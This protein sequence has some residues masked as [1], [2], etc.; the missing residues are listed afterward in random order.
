MS[1]R[2]TRREGWA[3]LD[4]PPTEQML[5]P[6]LCFVEAYAEKLGID[7][8]RRW[9]LRDALS[10]AF[11]LVVR[12][13][14]SSSGAA[15]PVVIEVGERE[16]QLVVEVL[17]AGVP[18]K[19]TGGTC[20]D[21]AQEFHQAARHLDRL[22][23]DNLGRRGQAV[24]LGIRLGEAAARKALAGSLGAHTEIEATDADIT[25]R[26]MEA[27]EAPLFSQ[28]FYYVYGYDYIHE[29]VYYPD[30]VRQMIEEGKLISLVGTLPNG[31]LVGHVGL[32]KWNDEPPVYE[33]C[34]GV[35]DPH[36]KSRGLFGK[37]FQRTM[38]TVAEIP[39]QYLMF[40]FVTN[41]E[42][43]Q[44]FVARY[45]PVDLAIFIGCQSK[46][47]QARL[48]KLGLGQDSAEM[49]RYSLLYSVLPRVEHPF[50]A[51]IEL[52]MNLGELLGFLL[53]PL[54]LHWYPASR[55]QLL[56]AGGEYRVTLQPA[57]SAV[58]FDL[59]QPGRDAVDRLISEWHQLLRN[60]YQYA[61]V[62]VL[63]ETPGLGNLYD[64]LAEAGFF[65]AG[66][67]PYH[68]SDK[69]GIRFQAIGPTKVAFDDIKVH[70]ETAKKLL[71]II[72]Q[73]YERNGLL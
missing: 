37:I 55:F 63:V 4:I 7:R 28:L 49:D 23:I 58:I 32:I 51:E 29:F 15:K 25:I 34:L 44:R 27:S 12:N 33:P 39:M 17:N 8:D 60:G 64:I 61:G 26:R 40:D 9:K 56:A 48:E 10:M 20:P 30:K 1:H 69:L 16:D 36:L 3:R 62:D 54:N 65:V 53:K 13:S 14:H 50:G 22:S 11:S 19:I 31:R 18:L 57:Q 38:E 42:L 68:H 6:A 71:A 41:H 21:A 35:V 67:M 5:E 70:T 24:V 73:N 46:E 52:P 66:F 72:R 2:E 47:T 59:V 43:S 45:H